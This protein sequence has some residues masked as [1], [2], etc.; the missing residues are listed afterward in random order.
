MAYPS[1][2]PFQ[3]STERP[4]VPNSTASLLAEPPVGVEAVDGGSGRGKDDVGVVAG[5]DGSDERNPRVRRGPGGHD[6]ARVGQPLVLA[7]QDLIL[8]RTR[9]LRGD[10]ERVVPRTRVV[11]R[12]AGSG[13]SWLPY[14]GSGV[15][16]MI[17]PG[18]WPVCSC[19]SS[20]ARSNPAAKSC[21]VTGPTWIVSI[22]HTTGRGWPWLS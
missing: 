16:S 4:S 8:E 12:A 11:R 21:G 5:K 7:D 2:F 17:Q 18:R 22:S 15:G 19:S 1:V 10:V 13:P 3:V 20:A 6:V 14:P 9:T